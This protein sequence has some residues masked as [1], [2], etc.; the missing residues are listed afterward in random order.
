LLWQKPLKLL[1]VMNM[2]YVDVTR[3][4][5]LR[6]LIYDMWRPRTEAGRMIKHFILTGSF[7]L[8]PRRGR[9]LLG[10]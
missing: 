2:S 9:R 10:G 3:L 7:E 8:P 5:P 6:K 1:K 4:G